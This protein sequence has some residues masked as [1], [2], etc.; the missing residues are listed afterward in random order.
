MK[1]MARFI[2]YPKKALE[3][4]QRLEELGLT[5]SYSVKTNPELVDFLEGKSECEFSAHSLKEAAVVKDKKR[6]W[7]FSQ[8]INKDVL[9]KVNKL[10]INKIVVDNEKDLE[11]VLGYVKKKK[12]EMELLLRM[13]LRENTIFTGRF[14]VFGMDTKQVNK[15]IERISS[16]EELSELIKKIG[17]HVHRKTQN[18]AEWNLK[19]EMEQSLRPETLER[20]SL[21]NLGGGLPIKYKNSDDQV[22]KYIFERLKEAKNWLEGRGIET[23]VEPGRFIAGPAV[24]LEA[25]VIRVFDNTIIIDC[26]IYNAAIDTIIAPLKLMVEGEYEEESEGRKKWVIK[27]KTPCSMDIF[28]YKVILDRGI[29]EGEKIRFLNAGAYNFKTDFCFLEKVEREVKEGRK[30][31]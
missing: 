11:I 13:K 4:I 20:I 7:F 8:A 14:F 26:S 6:V 23:V 30:G 28:R 27:G 24:V 10:G 5:V 2:I 31:N 12:W 3:Q 22:I 16:D 17:I 15:I 9:E 29:K 25:R 1:K 18:L 19:Y 21:V